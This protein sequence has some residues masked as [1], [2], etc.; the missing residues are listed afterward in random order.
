MAAIG[1]AAIFSGIWFLMAAILPPWSDE[2]S[3]L[4]AARGIFLTGRPFSV[5]FSQCA[6]LTPHQYIRGLELSQLMAWSYGIFGESLRAARTVPFVFTIGTWLLY[7]VYTRWR[8]Y[9]SGRLRQW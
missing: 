4:A 6:Q 7:I 3:Q 8:G 2:S 1:I 5:D 9:S